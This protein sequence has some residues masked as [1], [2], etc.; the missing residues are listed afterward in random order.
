VARARQAATRAGAGGQGRAHRSAGIQLLDTGNTGE[1]SKRAGVHCEGQMRM[2]CGDAHADS[3]AA[4]IS[5]ATHKAS[6]C[7][8]RAL[9]K[10]AIDWLSR[11]E[12]P[13]AEAAGG[14]PVPGP[15]V[16]KPAAL[17]GGGG[18]MGGGRSQYHLRQSLV[19]LDMPVL[20]KPEVMVRI[21]EAPPKNDP[22]T[23]D[24]IHEGTQKMVDQL[25]A[26]FAEWC[27]R[28]EM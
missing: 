16:L 9:Q 23:G 7:S 6:R 27:R 17:M 15:L 3:K 14:G 5:S 24:L 10:N 22:A 19:F 13:D 2:P 1:H 8:L 4:A 18:Y 20:M 25:L 21:F 11:P 26:S 28:L 12:L